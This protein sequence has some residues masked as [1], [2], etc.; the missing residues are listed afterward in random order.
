MPIPPGTARQGVPQRRNTLKPPSRRQFIG[1]VAQLGAAAAAS[2]VMPL[3]GHALALTAAEDVSGAASLGAH[4][5]TRGLLYGCA[6]DVP[7]LSAEPAY[8]ALIRQQCN[9]VVAENAMKWGGLRPAPETFHFDQ[10]DALM[11]FAEA[12]RIKVRGHNLAWHEWNPKWFDTYLT[13]ANAR[14][15]LVNHIRTV[16]GRYA[17]RIHSWD[18]VNEAID[19]KQGR[20]DGLRDS[21]WLRLVGEGYLDIAFR[22]AREADP[23]ALLTYNDYGIEAEPAVCPSMQLGCS[24]IS[25][26][27]AAT[28]PAPSQPAHNPQP[29]KR[30]STA[31][32]CSNSSRRSGSLGCRS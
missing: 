8:A 32:G 12:N 22:T 1:N 29:I 14:Q 6:V 3:A 18:V 2:S 28:Q 19:V 5:A 15:A 26:Q 11:A 7:A 16:A 23:K 27:P 17:G 21:V 24:R 31:P 10:A 30:R 9:L 20:P 4:A 13:A 25:M